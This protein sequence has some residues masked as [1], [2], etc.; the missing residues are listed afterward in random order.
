MQTQTCNQSVIQGSKPERVLKRALENLRSCGSASGLPHMIHP[1]RIC[2]SAPPA[3]RILHK[4]FDP[5]LDA[6]TY[7]YHFP[8]L[9]LLISHYY[10][11]YY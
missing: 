11:Y 5:Q 10:H 7:F 1:Y 2:P 8:F 6:L 9:L 4:T 3:L